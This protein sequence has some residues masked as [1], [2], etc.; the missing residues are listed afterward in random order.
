MGFA[1]CLIKP[2]RELYAATS[3]LTAIADAMEAGDRGRA[4]E[5]VLSI[6]LAACRLHWQEC[7]LEAARRHQKNHVKGQTSKRG[8]VSATMRIQIGERD[9]WRCRYCELPL[10]WEGFFRTLFAVEFIGM[11]DSVNDLW[12]IF[13]QSPDH[14]VPVAAGGTNAPTNVVSACGSCNY[15]KSA[16]LL[17][18]LGLDEP[19]AR[20]PI[21]DGWRGLVGRPHAGTPGVVWT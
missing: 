20:D 4:R 18:E 1:N 21:L 17:G 5:V 7:G 11:G 2:P 9:G 16:C 15:S 3:Q 19:W 14:V 13:G 10:V 6:D 12:R 8:A